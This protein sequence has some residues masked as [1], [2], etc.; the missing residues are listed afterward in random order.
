MEGAGPGPEQRPDW[1]S[2]GPLP[3]P[4]WASA[5]LGPG[6]AVHWRI[7]EKEGVSEPAARTPHP[8]KKNRAALTSGELLHSGK[9]TTAQQDKQAENRHTQAHFHTAETHSGLKAMLSMSK[10]H[11]L[12]LR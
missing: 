6:Q 11:A 12:R 4:D 9:V 10:A 5:V 7:R 2:P 8:N 3:P 1:P